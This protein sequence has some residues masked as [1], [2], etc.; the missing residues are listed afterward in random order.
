MSNYLVLVQTESTKDGKYDLWEDNT[1]EQYHYPNGYKNRIQPGKSFIYYKTQLRKG[2][3][4]GVA[5]YFGYG[6]I[7][8]VF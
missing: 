3:G 4:T 7:G 6:V 8:E 1:G 5:G 2:G